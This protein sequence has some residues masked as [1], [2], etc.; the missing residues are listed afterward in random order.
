MVQF[1]KP[2]DET[3]PMKKQILC[4]IPILPVL[5]STPRASAQSILLPFLNPGITNTV[6]ESSDAASSKFGL[7]I[8]FGTA[9]FARPGEKGSI[10]AERFAPTS[11]DVR[12][13]VR[14]A[15]QAGMTLAV[16]TAKHE[17]GFC[18]WHSEGY[19][20]D[21]AKS[22]FKGD[23]IA[24][25]VAACK[26]EGIL[27]GVHYSVPDAY[28]EGAVRFQGPVPPPYFEV[29]KKQLTELHTRYPGLRVQIL[30]VANRLTPAQLDELRLI[31]KRLNPE[32]A[33]W[34]GDNDP[35]SDTIIKGWMWSPNAKLNPPQQ[36]FTRYQQS[37]ADGK[38]FLLNV[39]PDTTGRIPDDQ[40]AVLTRVKE[41]I[42][43]GD[44]P[45]TAESLKRGLILHFDFDREPVAG[46]VVDTSGSGN[47]GVA[48]G[49]QW[50]ADGHRGGGAGFSL[51]NSYI[52][53][54]NNASLNPTNLTLVAW[55]K[56]SWSDNVWR[57]IIDKQWNHG[58]AVSIAG[59]YTGKGKETSPKS[60]GFATSEMNGHYMGTDA[61]VD[62][63]QW[64]QIVTTFDGMEQMLF[65]DG[66]PQRSNRQWNG[67]VAA[68]EFDLTI[69]ANRSNPNAQVDEIGSSFNG[70]MDDVMVFNRALSAAEVK[71]LYDSQKTAADVPLAIPAPQPKN[72]PAKAAPPA[73][74]KPAAA[75][76]LKQV[77]DLYDQG[78]INKDEYDKKRQEI[79]DSM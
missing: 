10:P 33:V 51:T 43:Q 41:L 18:L 3:K 16:L 23:I 75:E 30:D 2:I 42:N 29:I 19:D 69:G 8:H 20:Y 65:A 25:F 49:V 39:G 70:M 38:T 13:W 11:L 26:A 58:F 71:A 40:L 1:Y 12:S 37:Q 48:V 55:I 5:L 56:T 60:K 32:C 45:I 47:N 22:P 54:P 36:L 17:S 61:K 59:A 24:E 57:R 21:V 50:V 34:G 62:D 78:L 66:I 44:E 7:Y 46:K 53:V 52:R 15:K 14:T 35:A 68:N 31:V 27:P 67:A 76:R 74:N 77:K 79:L 6:S 64:H 72:T 73:Q 4:L 63:G 9:T 28:N